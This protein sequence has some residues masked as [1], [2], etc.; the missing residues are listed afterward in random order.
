MAVVV[1]QKTLSRLIEDV[2]EMSFLNFQHENVYETSSGD[3]CYK[4]HLLYDAI[5][6]EIKDVDWEKELIQYQEYFDR[7]KNCQKVK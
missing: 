1:S 2:V 7:R 5:R 3:D 4:I 6:S